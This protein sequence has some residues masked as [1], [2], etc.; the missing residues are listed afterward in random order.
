MDNAFSV[1]NGD[2]AY[3]DAGYHP[4]VCAPGASLY[5]LTLMAGP[6]RMSLSSVHGSYRYLL[7]DNAM[8]N[9]YQNQRSRP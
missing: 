7:E 9:P 1:K 4:V 8:V 2:V 5:Q 3:M 6:K